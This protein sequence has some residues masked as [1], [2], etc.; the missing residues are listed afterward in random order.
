VG[1]FIGGMCIGGGEMW[2]FLLFWLGVVW[3]ILCIGV[4]F[5]P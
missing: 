1:C 4:T 2:V 5:I 3:I